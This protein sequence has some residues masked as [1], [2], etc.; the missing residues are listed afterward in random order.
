VNWVMQSFEYHHTSYGQELLAVF[1]KDD[2]LV[3]FSAITLCL[4]LIF[5]KIR[6]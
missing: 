6:T 3:R 5:S 2:D 4:N 1:N